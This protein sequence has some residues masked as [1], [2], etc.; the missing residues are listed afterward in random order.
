VLSD[1]SAPLCPACDGPLDREHVVRGVDRLHG[2]PG[3]FSVAVCKECG[4][5][6]SFPRSAPEQLATYYPAAYGPYELT[7]RGLAGAVSWMIRWYQGR[8][9]LTRKPLSVLRDK[10]PG[11]L[12][13]VGCGRGDIAATF[14]DR[15]WRAVGVEPSAAACAVARERGVDAKE[16]TLADVALEADAYDAALFHH[17]LEHSE[18]PASDLERA[19]RALRPG[20]LALVTVPNFGSWQRRRFRSAWYHLD[21]PRHRT[22]FT[23]AGLAHALERAGLRVE[24]MTTSTSTVGLP[25]TIQYALVGRCLFPRGLSLRVASGLCILTLPVAQVCDA[26]TGGG[27]QL[28]AVARRPS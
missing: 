1:A 14:V 24:S 18:D 3:E 15:G 16:G 21:L 19:A 4:S 5:G 25:A 20:G 26:V 28:N 27:D 23:A 17:S 13:D 7:T 2:V 9:G 11:R 8:R 6:V 10:P 22:H 12:L